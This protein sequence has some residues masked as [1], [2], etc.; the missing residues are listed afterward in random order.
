[1]KNFAKI[2]LM[3]TFNERMWFLELDYDKQKK[4]FGMFFL[5]PVGCI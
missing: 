4:K 3:M 1:M 2:K 5:G